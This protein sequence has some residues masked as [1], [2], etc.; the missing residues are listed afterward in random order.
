MIIY[1]SLLACLTRQLFSQV[2]RTHL[3]TAFFRIQIKY[4]GKCISAYIKTMIPLLR[5]HVVT[6]QFSRVIHSDATTSWGLNIPCYSSIGSAA[7]FVHNRVVGEKLLRR[8]TKITI[9][10]KIVFM[11]F[12]RHYLLWIRCWFARWT[13]KW[14]VSIRSQSTYT[15]AQ[16]HLKL[17]RNYY[18]HKWSNA[19]Y[20]L[21][22]KKKK[23]FSPF[24]QLRRGTTWSYKNW[25]LLVLIFFRQKWHP[26]MTLLCAMIAP[27]LN[28]DPHDWLKT[29]HNISL[30]HRF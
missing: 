30:R 13:A 6:W 3:T 27:A 11:R 24:T 22:L 26:L 12:T 7:W 8:S 9:S 21:E 28:K 18:F 29:G 19:N 25:I 16:S 17:K 14:F 23:T 15:S 10:H 20:P 2:T 4:L 1:R 5:S